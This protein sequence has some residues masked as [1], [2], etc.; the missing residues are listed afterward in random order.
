MPNMLFIFPLP[1]MYLN[2]FKNYLMVPNSA[3]LSI[4]PQISALVSPRNNV[5][6][7]PL[8]VNPAPLLRTQ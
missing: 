3:P 7:S 5:T 2:W 8:P 6:P 4:I 1:L